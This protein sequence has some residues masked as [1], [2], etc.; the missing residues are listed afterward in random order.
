MNATM[1][2]DMVAF[3]KEDKV[4]DIKARLGLQR[5]VSFWREAHEFHFNSI[6]LLIAPWS[7]L[8][9]FRL[10]KIAALR[11]SCFASVCHVCLYAKFSYASCF[12]HFDKA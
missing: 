4:F 9:R 12:L 8:K 6:L 3:A 10:E 1:E 7:T 2:N 5:V 11:Y